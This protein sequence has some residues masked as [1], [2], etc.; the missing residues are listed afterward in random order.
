[1][2]L[3]E[4]LR[5]NIGW[6]VAVGLLALVQVLPPDTS[7]SEMKR[8]G[9]LRVC[10]PDHYPPLVTR[11]IELP[12][13]D[14]EVVRSVS[15]RIGVRLGR[16]AV[17]DMARDWNPRNWRVTR[18]HCQMLAGGVVNSEQTRV[19]LETSQPYLETGWALI[20]P[21]E[22]GDLSG[23]VVG[24]YAG[25]SGL[26]RVALSR[27][28]RQQGAQVQLVMDI[29]RLVD[30][31]ASGSLDAGVSEALSARQAAWETDWS[32]QWLP[33]ELGR[34]QIALGLWKGDLTL[35]R[36]VNKAL[37]QLRDE[38]ELDAIFQR[39]HLAPID[40]VCTPCTA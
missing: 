20:V 29:Q 26:D 25:V 32:V 23:A 33:A 4:L 27:F 10:L 35:K 9:V 2:R 6:L 36:A 13:I 38:G 39:Y 34:Y 40:D 37:T 3:V 16:N 7:L 17:P 1:M 12:G 14:V 5:G 19:F 18:S 8:V 21:S 15:E 22:L 11:D 31:L 28:L 30:G 24:V